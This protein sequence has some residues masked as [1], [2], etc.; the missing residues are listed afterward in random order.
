MKKKKKGP[1]KQISKKLQNL[2][3]A[4]PEVQKIFKDAISSLDQ[5]ICADCSVP[6]PD[7]K[8]T[9]VRCGDE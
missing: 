7:S 3:P 4:Q 5:N 9:C 8:F 2:T 6:I 1:S